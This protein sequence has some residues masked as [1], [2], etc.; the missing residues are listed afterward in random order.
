MKTFKQYTKEEHID[1]HYVFGFLLEA[2]DA[3][4]WE[5]MVQDRIVTKYRHTFSVPNKSGEPQTVSV[6]I[7]HNKKLGNHTVRFNVGGL[8]DAERVSQDLPPRSRESALRGVARALEHHARNRVAPGEQISA[9]TYDSGKK[10][11][12][13]RKTN[14]QRRFFQKL[15]GKLGGWKYKSPENDEFHSIKKPKNAA[16]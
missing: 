8:F 12:E 16:A 6:D 4:K 3:P 13:E 11:T 9:T 7:R 15:A 2:E 5:E 1:W 14:L 10:S